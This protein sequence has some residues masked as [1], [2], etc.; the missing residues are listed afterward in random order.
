LHSVSF[1]YD[2]GVDERQLPDN[3]A[4]LKCLIGETKE[5]LTSKIVGLD[6]G[7]AVLVHAGYKVFDFTKEQ[8]QSTTKS[9][10][11]IKRL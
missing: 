1:C 9:Q 10:R 2:D 6:R 4:H 3:K 8:K 11:Y 5:S 7:V